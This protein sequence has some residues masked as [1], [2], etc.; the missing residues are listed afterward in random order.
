MPSGLE[1]WVIDC[2]DT[3]FKTSVGIINFIIA[4]LSAITLLLYFKYD[5]IT[6]LTF[7]FLSMVLCVIC[8][9]YYYIGIED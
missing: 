4:T 2:L 1:E 7:W 5:S 8:V 6:T 3:E 9:R